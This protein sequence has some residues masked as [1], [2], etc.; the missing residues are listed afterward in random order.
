[1]L[2]ERCRDTSYS[3]PQSNRETELHLQTSPLYRDSNTLLPPEQAGVCFPLLTSLCLPWS[4]D[5]SN[6]SLQ[7]F[8]R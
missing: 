8:T 5:G 1:M 3:A 7:V 2:D 4:C 6:P